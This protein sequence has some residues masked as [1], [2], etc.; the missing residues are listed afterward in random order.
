MKFVL[1]TYATPEFAVHRDRL[2]QSARQVGFDR[3][4]AQGPE[5][6]SAT[7]FWRRNQ[8]VLTKPRGGGYWLWKPFIIREALRGCGPDDVL[9][10]SDAGSD[11]YYHF[12]VLP[13]RIAK[14]TRNLPGG[15]LLGAT[16]PHCGPLRVWTKRDCLIL[17]DGDRPEIFE[18]PLI[19]A[20]WSVWTNTGPAFEF[21]ENWLAAC[22][23]PRRLTDDHNECERP[24]YDGFIEHRHD[25]SIASILAAIRGIDGLDIG[26]LPGAWGYEY[27][28]HR[29]RN[30][31]AGHRFRK[32][33]SNVE[34]VLRGVPAALLFAKELVRLKMAGVR[35]SH[36][37]AR[38]KG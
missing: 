1:L 20:T 13:V 12:S 5:A 28:E 27:L 26:N 9:V 23:D 29:F 32:R 31:A 14:L 36:V 22:E 24:N 33:L 21:L 8:S 30:S 11:A 18:R 6:L 37:A 19:Q 7:D 4:V 25:Q 35:K 15:F 38:A 10:Y 34:M 17:C 16:I 2:V 3:I